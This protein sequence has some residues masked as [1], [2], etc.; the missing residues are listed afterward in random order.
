MNEMP[1]KARLGERL[2]GERTDW[3]RVDALSEAALERAVRD[4]PD[5]FGPGAEWIA[6]VAVP[7]LA[8]RRPARR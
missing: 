1:T 6:R 3:G 2:E 4:D 8:V 5:T 7:R